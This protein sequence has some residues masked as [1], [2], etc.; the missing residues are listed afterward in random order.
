MFRW[1]VVY[2][3]RRRSTIK[4]EFITYLS[5][6]RPSSK[7]APKKSQG[8]WWKHDKNMEEFH[9]V[10]SFPIALFSTVFKFSCAL[11]ESFVMKIVMKLKQRS[12]MD[13]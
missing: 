4:F 10:K 5:N 11:V 9:R 12:L 3:T 8:N 7:P 13:I 2:D 6:F 1:I